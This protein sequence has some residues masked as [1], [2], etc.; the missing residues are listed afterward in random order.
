MTMS[1]KSALSDTST[2]TLPQPTSTSAPASP[3]ALKT[4]IVVIGTGQAGLSSAY[5]LAELVGGILVIVGFLTPLAALALIVVMSVAVL[6]VHL[7]NGYFNTN[8]GYEFNLALGG[9]A[10]TLLIAGAG[11]YSLDSLLGIFW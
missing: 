2:L 8:G 9:L 11:A 5:R 6:T 7:K 3:V 4:D 10:L 1:T